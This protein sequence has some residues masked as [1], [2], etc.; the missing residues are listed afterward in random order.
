MATCSSL[1]RAISESAACVRTAP[2]TRSRAVLISGFDENS[3]DRVNAK[4]LAV[5]LLS[6]DE[7]VQRTHLAHHVRKIHRAPVRFVKEV[8][9][10]D[11]GWARKPDRM[12]PENAARIWSTPIGEAPRSSLTDEFSSR[13]VC[14]AVTRGVKVRSKEATPN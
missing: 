14:F 1:I 5:L 6:L 7:I 11:S 9:Q 12:T 13:D 10:L 8:R 3:S 2:S 4:N